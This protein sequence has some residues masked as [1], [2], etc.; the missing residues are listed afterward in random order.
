[1]TTFESHDDEEFSARRVEIVHESLLANWPR[2]VRW[3]TQDQEGA[4][5]RDD[6]RQAAKTW[7]EHGRH[8]DRL[9]T[10]TVYREFRLWSERYPGGLTEIE[11]TFGSAMTAY[12]GRRRRRRRAMVA[13]VMSVLVT[14]LVVVGYFWQRSVREALR[15]EGAN[16]V[17]LGQIQLESYPSATVAHAIAS[18]ELADSESARSLAQAALWRGPTALVANNHHSWWVRFNPSGDQM[19]QSTVGAPA[20][21]HI[22][23]R[24]GREKTLEPPPDWPRVLFYVNPTG[25]HLFTHVWATAQAEQHLVLWSIPDGRR[26]ADLRYGAPSSLSGFGWKEHEI[27]LGVFEN[28]RGHIDAV[29]FDGSVK[30]LD[31]PDLDFDLRQWHRQTTID[32][33]TGRWF[34]AIE[35]GNVKLYEIGNTGLSAPRVLGRQEGSD[36]RSI[37]GA[38]GNSLLT[39]NT[40]GEIQIWDP[41]EV[42]PSTVIQ[43]PRGIH[44]LV[45][46]GDGS[47]IEGCTVKDD[48]LVS[49]VWSLRNEE[50]EL[51]R[52]IDLG[53]LGMGYYYMGPR[54]DRVAR[55]GPDKSVR[56]WSLGAPFDAEPVSLLRGDI[57]TQWSLAFHPSG[58]VLA[59]AD[60][61]GVSIWPLSRRYPAVIRRHSEAVSSVVFEPGG[62]WLASAGIEG[63]VWRWPLE[64]LAPTKGEMVF[65]EDSD[66]SAVAISPDIDHLLVG[67][68]LDRAAVKPLK[69]G[70]TTTLEGAL[71]SVGVAFS[72]DGTMAA[73]LGNRPDNLAGVTFVYRVGHWDEPV[74]LEHEN[75]AFLGWPKFQSDGRVLACGPPGLWR[76]DPKNGRSQLLYEKGVAGFSMSRDE[77]LVALVETPDPSTNAPSR[78]TVVNLHNRVSRSL[79]THG[80]LVSAI[81]LHPSGSWLVSGDKEGTIRVGPMDGGVPHLLFGHEGRVRSVAIDP[82][83]RWIASGGEDGTV[84]LWPMPDLTKP[85]LHTLPREELIAKLKTL[86]NLRVVR[87]PESSTGWTLTHDPFPGWE[88]VPTW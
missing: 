18:L 36:P 49:W 26:L 12:S 74:V 6:L 54:G 76:L 33:E 59:T 21:L 55:A 52:R 69:G 87:D 17:S 73:V 50:A 72:G 75:G 27:I 88:T 13:S 81:A 44:G 64:G 45:L 1:L 4:Q 23:D 79:Q 9:W 3:Q 65:R 53:P 16:L 19:I 84:R 7:N 85:P 51:L 20:P 34:A 58:D 5:L 63:A 68:R 10:G 22:I 71:Q 29:S 66:I 35:D 30:R 70:P 86:T 61:A 43:G 40:G 47:V 60:E 46:A 77:N 32:T 38:D 48:R 15:A 39:T 11:E 14:G 62:R 2:L 56:L 82:Q 80:D 28:D 78:V 42:G 37:F 25:T 57:G 41:L 31:S 8:D 24:T 67:R 83:E